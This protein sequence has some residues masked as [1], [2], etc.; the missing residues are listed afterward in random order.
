MDL[1]YTDR[2]FNELGYLKD[3]TL[4]LEIGKYGAAPNDFELTLK[5]NVLGADCLFYCENTEYGGIIDHVKVNTETN[6][7]TYIGKTFR[8]LLEK[9]YVQPP[10]GQTHLV[11]NGD[12]N[13]CI[14]T[15]ING[16][17]NDLFVADGESGISIK[18]SVRDLNLLDALEKSLATQNAKLEIEHRT[19]GKVHL[20]A[21]K[22]ND[23]SESI[24]YDS[25]YRV[26]MVVES[27]SKPYNHILALGKGELLERLRINIY[28]QKDGTWG[29]S[30]YFKG[31]DRRTYKYDDSNTEDAEE[32]KANA[33]NKV[34]EENGT[35]NLDVS[36]D[37]DNAELFDIVGAKEEITG[38]SFKQAITRKIIKISNNKVS[39]DYKVGD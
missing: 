9:E 38:I 31:M 26:G 19:D 37:S 18:Y 7:I 14:R 35:D 34:V 23:L 15:L 22:V 4:D 5:E 28:L 27:K 6:E 16:R 3:F 12:A 21:A 30:E 17:F 29:T 1:I 11:L 2:N 36:F 25:S 20:K 10:E 33:I 8:G 24:Q 32:L 39:I 13:E